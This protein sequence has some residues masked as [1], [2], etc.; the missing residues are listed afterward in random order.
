MLCSCACFS[1]SLRTSQYHWHCFVPVAVKS[2]LVPIQ[3]LNHRN[4]SLKGLNGRGFGKEAWPSHAGTI[5]VLRSVFSPDA[6]T[7]RAV[8]RA[9]EKQGLAQEPGA[10]HWFRLFLGAVWRSGLLSKAGF[11]MEDDVIHTM[12][13]GET[14]HASREGSKL[15]QFCARWRSDLL[16]EFSLICSL[17]SDFHFLSLLGLYQPLTY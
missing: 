10:S 7:K 6:N 14:K 16:L 5:K 1:H 2:V 12:L 13:G 11:V 9:Y 17:F 4:P 3:S 15:L 8:P